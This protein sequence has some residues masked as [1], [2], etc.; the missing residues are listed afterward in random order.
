M[1]GAY[2]AGRG[3]RT[4]QR[5]RDPGEVN[6]PRFKT[7]IVYRTTPESDLIAVRRLSRLRRFYT[8]S[9]LIYKRPPQL[10]PPLEIHITPYLHVS[11]AHTYPWYSAAI[12]S[13]K[14]R[15]AGADW[16][17]NRAAESF[18]TSFEDRGTSLDAIQDTAFKCQRINIPFTHVTYI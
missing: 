6:G 13:N 1:K 11:A 7:R 10:R 12:R 5:L 9:T 16:T 15:T 3:Q 18:P 4:H 8:A 2:K 17:T 14:I